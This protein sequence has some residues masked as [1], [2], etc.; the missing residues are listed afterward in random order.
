MIICVICGPLRILKRK[1]IKWLYPNFPVIFHLLCRLI[2]I[3]ILLMSNRRPALVFIFITLLIDVIGFGIIIPVMPKLISSMTG[4]GMS[5]ASRI[6]G[7][8]MF[9]YSVMMFLFAPVLGNLSDRFGRRPIILISLF[10]L[11]IDYLFL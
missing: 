1:K 9:A 11:G 3:R 6:G 5:E 8:L 7:W 2:F 4:G 10:G